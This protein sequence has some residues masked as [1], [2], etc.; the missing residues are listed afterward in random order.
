MTQINKAV[1]LLLTLFCSTALASNAL[2][3]SWTKAGRNATRYSMGMDKSIAYNGDWSAFIASRSDKKVLEKEFGTLMQSADV[4]KYR[5][6]RIKMTVFIKT[7]NVSG[8][9]GAWLRVN[10]K[11]KRKPLAFDNMY[12]RQIQGTTDWT[13][14]A[15]VMDVSRRASKLHYGVL[16]SGPGKV[17]FD[18][19]NFAVVDKRTPVTDLYAPPKDKVAITLNSEQTK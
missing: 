9:A 14:Y 19:I 3:E 7:E 13:E 17:W 16:L 18:Y 6:K 5:G 4:T 8:W 10:G 12:D 1:L 11:R 2:P 15:L